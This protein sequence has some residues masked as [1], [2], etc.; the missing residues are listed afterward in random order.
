M[1]AELNRYLVKKL[2]LMFFCIFTIYGLNA[3]T[4]SYQSGQRQYECTNHLGNVVETVS[5]KKES[6]TLGLRASV[7]SFRDYYPYGMQMAKR[8]G[9]SSTYRYGFNGMEGDDEVKGKGN[10]LNFGARIY[11]PRIGR[12]LSRDAFARDYVPI[13]SYVFALNNPIYFVDPD[14]NTIYDSEGNAVTIKPN[15]DGTL[16]I[17]G[18]TDANLSSLLISTW[19]DS[20][21]G[22]ST[23]KKLNKKKIKATVI[24]HSERSIVLYEG[25]DG[26]KNAGENVG[27]SQVGD[28]NSEVLIEIFGYDAETVAN[29]Q[30]DGDITDYTITDLNAAEGEQDVDPESLSKEEIA[31]I[32]SKLQEDKD[33]HQGSTGADASLSEANRKAYSVINEADKSN[34]SERNINTFIFEA[35]NALGQ[36]QMYAAGKGDAE[37]SKYGERKGRKAVLNRANEKKSTTGQ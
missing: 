18:T 10:S 6:T 36:A 33:T 9:T 29:G 35:A 19:N 16:T 15:K 1:G 7:S 2:W 4:R 14:G 22:K 8:K 34:K 24:V 17:T 37:A 27:F 31:F 30:L 20:E 11:D 12:W 25:K 28:D 5:D 26:E 13:S 3:Q 23:I 21:E 32:E